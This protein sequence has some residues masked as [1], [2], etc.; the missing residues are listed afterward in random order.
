MR[1]Q[2]IWDQILE[3]NGKRTSLYQKLDDALNTYKTSKDLKIY[4]EQ[5]KKIDGELKLVQQDLTTFAM[6]AKSDSADAAEKVRIS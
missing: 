5:R 4:N 3:S 1:L 2:A 6:K